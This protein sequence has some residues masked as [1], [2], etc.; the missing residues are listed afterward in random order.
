MSE[1]MNN[2]PLMLAGYLLL[3]AS[4]LASGFAIGWRLRTRVA[5]RIDDEREE[6]ASV[7]AKAVTLRCM[8]TGRN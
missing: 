8:K 5:E 3:G 1:T 2:L 6:V 4:V 7:V